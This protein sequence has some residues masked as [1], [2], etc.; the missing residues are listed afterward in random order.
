MTVVK[1]SQIVTAE[2]NNI[3]EKE[4]ITLVA[5]NIV[6]EN[7]DITTYANNDHRAFDP[8]LATTSLTITMLPSDTSAMQNI[9]GGPHPT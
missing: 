5:W 7:N 9:M 6:Y 2:F 1:A 4:S 3:D 8:S